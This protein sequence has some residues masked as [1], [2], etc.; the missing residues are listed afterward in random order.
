MARVLVQ[1]SGALMATRCGPPLRVPAEVDVEVLQGLGLRSVWRGPAGALVEVTEDTRMDALVTLVARSGADELRLVNLRAIHAR[2]ESQ[3]EAVLGPRGAA[4]CGGC[5]VEQLVLNGTVV[6]PRSC[7]VLGHGSD[8]AWLE[9]YVGLVGSTLARDV[10]GRVPPDVRLEPKAV[11]A[12]WVNPVWPWADG[13]AEADWAFL[14]MQFEARSG[15]VGSQR[16]LLSE[17]GAYP[18]LD[19]A[20]PPVANRMMRRRPVTWALLAVL[21]MGAVLGAL[22]LAGF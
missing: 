1:G 18:G 5:V 15:A 7:H 3:R 14:E 4:A 16:R 9:G 19:E 17:W 8:Q 13:V 22:W 10:L 12:V 6:T 21:V 20:P 11:A 2:T